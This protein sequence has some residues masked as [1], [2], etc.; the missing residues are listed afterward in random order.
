MTSLDLEPLWQVAEAQPSVPGRGR[1]HGTHISTAFGEILIAINE[2]GTRAVLFPTRSDDAFASDTSTKVQVTRRTL[3]FGGMEQTHIAVTCIVDRLKA[4]FTTLASDM[5]QSSDGAD[6]PSEVILSTLDEW[7][8]LLSGEPSQPLAESKLVGL[9]AE[10]LTLRAVLS[11]DPDRDVTIWSGPEEA[12]H[13]IR[14]GTE[15]L[16]VK[17]TLNR[18]GLAVEIHGL[19]QLEAP[20]N[21]RL[22]LVIYRL[23]RDTEH[24]QS[25]PDLVR[26]IL[27]LG[28]SRVEFVRRLGRCGYDLADENQYAAIRFG[29]VQRYVFVV[30]NQFPRIVRASLVD[31]DVPAGVKLLRYTVDLGGTTPSTLPAHEADAAIIA[32]AGAS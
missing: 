6:R 9:A 24:G 12:L 8:E 1:A 20:T 10:L 17:G 13:D 25:V 19:R 22:H 27:D 31:G 11:S 30:D 2:D 14:R 23:E 18:E 21:G 28:V 29:V 26:S 3:R 16:E 7:R 5:I 32:L 4:V 15:A